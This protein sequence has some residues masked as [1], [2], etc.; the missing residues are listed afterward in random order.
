M[1]RP[2]NESIFLR[3]LIK[4]G[5]SV[6]NPTLRSNLEWQDEKYWRVHQALWEKGQIEKGRGRGGVVLLVAPDNEGASAQTIAE[7]TVVSD[8]D[9]IEEVAAPIERASESELYEPIHKM[10]MKHWSRSQQLDECHCEIIAHQGKRDTGGSWSRPDLC[11]VGS[12]KFEYYP[13]RV[14]ELHTFEVKASTDVTIK[15][16][17]EALAHREAATRSYVLYHTGEKDFTS[18]PESS[19]IE[20]LAS[21]H[22]VG[23]IVAND[24]TDFDSWDTVVP[25]QRSLSDPEVMNTFISRSLSK[26]AQKKI[27]GWFSW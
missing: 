23:V 1:A 27:S 16:V 2:S 26:I 25:A 15:G 14:F 22:G 5:G 3:A 13:A 9:F 7:L 8:D 10:L 21:R 18:Y 6:S 12:R 4:A 11:V 19:R 17:L 20:E 24:V